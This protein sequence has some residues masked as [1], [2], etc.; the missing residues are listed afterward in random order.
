M[1]PPKIPEKNSIGFP[2]YTKV[3]FNSIYATPTLMNYK[4]YYD[5]FKE[6]KYSYGEWFVF[7][8]PGILSPCNDWF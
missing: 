3:M 4:L 7:P 6:E 8:V 5:E 2:I 1:P